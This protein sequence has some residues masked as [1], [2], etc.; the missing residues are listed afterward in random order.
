MFDPRR[1][2]RAERAIDRARAAIAAA[3]GTLTLD[4]ELAARAYVIGALLREL[5][6]TLRGAPRRQWPTTPAPRLGAPRSTLEHALA[7]L[8]HEVDQQGPDALA[9]VP[10]IV[11]AELRRRH[12]SL[13]AAVRHVAGRDEPSTPG[14]IDSATTIVLDGPTIAGAAEPP[15]VLDDRPNGL[16]NAGPPAAAD[17]VGS[18]E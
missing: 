12:G 8:A 14:R 10:R 16:Q 1:L 13:A 6:R 2:E 7:R 11:A 5:E 3:W 18:A 9:E 15:T 17:P 4:L